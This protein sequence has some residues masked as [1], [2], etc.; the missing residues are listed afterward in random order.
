MGIY[1]SG[2]I[3][4]IRIYNYNTLFEIKQDEMISDEQKKEAYSFYTGLNNKNDIS[5][6]FYTECSS[7]QDIDNKGKIMRWYPMSL[8][9]FLEKFAI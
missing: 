2:I 3:F 6:R 4:G 9:S 5:F 1:A 8:N 7:T